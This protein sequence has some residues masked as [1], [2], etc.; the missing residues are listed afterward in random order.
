LEQLEQERL[1]A[2][3]WLERLERMEW[4]DRLGPRALEVTEPREALVWELKE[5]QEAR[6]LLDRLV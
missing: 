5:V 6:A 3:G 4:M 2:L 1:E